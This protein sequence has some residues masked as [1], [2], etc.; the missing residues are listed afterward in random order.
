GDEL[1]AKGFEC[2]GECGSHSGIKSARQL[3]SAYLDAHNLSV[4]AHTKLAEAESAK[5]VFALLDYAESFPRNWP[6]IFD[7]R[8][9]T[10][11]GRLIPD[12]QAG[13]AREVA[14]ILF[15]QPGIAQGCR[16]SV[17]LSSEL[18]RAEVAL[19]IQVYSVGNRL[20][21]MLAAEIFHH[22]EQFIF[23][24]KAARSVIA[25]VF[26][27]VE[28]VGCDDF[29]RNPVLAGKCNRVG[30]L[31]ASQ[32]GRVCDDGQHVVTEYLM[33]RPCQEC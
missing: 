22:G 17:L 8:R 14:N 29:E 4:V 9:K 3:V 23:T 1:E 16:D 25:R 33:C 6:A 13:G 32:T 19:V 26:R 18:A 28:F 5:G 10:C 11:R 30:K 7:A 21:A 20:E 15:G 2:S 31:S 27:A 24:E 12:A